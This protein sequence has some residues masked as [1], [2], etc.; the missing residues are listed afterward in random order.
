MKKRTSLLMCMVWLCAIAWPQSATITI[1][2]A[3]AEEQGR[4]QNPGNGQEQVNVPVLQTR[5]AELQT[6]KIYTVDG[7]HFSVSLPTLPAMT[8]RDTMLYPQRKSRRDRMLGAY[9]DG[10]VYSVCVYENV[11]RQ[12]LDAFIAEQNRDDGWDRSTETPVSVKGVQGRQYLAR[13]KS[14]RAMVQFFAAEGRLYKFSA[15]GDIVDAAAVK[16]FFDSIVLGTNVEGI[17]VKDGIGLPFEAAEGETVVAGKEVNRKVRLFQ[18]PEPRYT[19]Q[20]RQEEVTG[21]VVLKAVFSSSGS[22]TNIRVVSELPSGLTERAIEAAKKIKF[23]PAIKDGKYASMWLQ[24]EY[25][26][27]LY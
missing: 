16:H 6:W 8:T 9:A 3:K 22:V 12:T 26:F 14:L 5:Q 21:T 4:G 19:E 10:A 20:A 24:L 11:F 27:N 13:D 23:L 2:S 25:N 17:K 18:K 7:E 1:G 15:G